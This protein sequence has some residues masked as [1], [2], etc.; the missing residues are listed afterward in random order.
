MNRII[1]IPARMASTRLP[2]KPLADINGRSL[3]EWVWRRGWSSRAG[4]VVIATDDDDIDAAAHGFGARVI[5]TRSDH[6]SGTDR[7]AEAVD[8]LEITDD[9][10]VVNLQGDEPLMPAACLDQVAGL[11]DD[12]A[13]ADMATLW[14]PMTDLRDAASPDVVKVV[15]RGDGRALYFSR[16]PIPHIRAGGTGVPVRRH[17]GLYAYRAGRLRQ[18]P[19][20]PPSALE[21]CESLEQLRALDAGWRIATAEAVEAI[22]AGVDTPADLERVRAILV[23][24]T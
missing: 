13:G 21:A 24:G 12:D 19:M 16:A 4:E 5:R 15:C 18:W 10:V 22:P 11:L 1:I 14:T 7:L 23:P 8:L 9:T 2:N 17:V 6:L 20:L 3:L